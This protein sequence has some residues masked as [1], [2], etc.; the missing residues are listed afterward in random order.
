MSVNLVALCVHY[1]QRIIIAIGIGQNLDFITGVEIQI[2]FVGQILHRI[3]SRA[4]GFIV[5][6]HISTYLRKQI[7][8]YGKMKIFV[9]LTVV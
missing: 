7:H 4:S 8:I 2:L 6:I 5:D 9:P 3:F 1:I